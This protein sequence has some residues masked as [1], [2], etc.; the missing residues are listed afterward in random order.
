MAKR[1]EILQA[2]IQKSDFYGLDLD[3]PEAFS[4]KL[5]IPTTTNSTDD[6]NV[7]VKP[8]ALV[9]N[10][11]LA[12]FDSWQEVAA[13]IIRPTEQDK[14]SLAKNVWKCIIDEGIRI[15]TGLLD[16]YFSILC[17]YGKGIVIID[18]VSFI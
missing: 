5:A 14:L 6:G 3:D 13:G 9:T 2:E 1:R 8:I 18:N 11:D 15:T 12:K 16:D 7:V 10:D 17:L 4:L